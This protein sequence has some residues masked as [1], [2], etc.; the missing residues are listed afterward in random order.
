MQSRRS[1]AAS[2]V[3]QWL[4]TRYK[5]AIIAATSAS[6]AGVRTEAMRRVNPRFV[7]RRWVV[8]EVL[9]GML[10]AKDPSEARKAL[11][12]ILEVSCST[13]MRGTDHL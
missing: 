5:P 9:D 13:Q 3:E 1:E 7:L 6:D 8:E 12:E 2:A 11:Y 10:A 4:Q